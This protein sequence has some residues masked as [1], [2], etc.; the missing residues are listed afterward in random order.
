MHAIGLMSG[1]SL[2]GVDAA[3]IGTDGER[4]ENFGPTYYRP[5]S[6]PERALLRRALADAVPITERTARPGVLAEAESLVTRTHAEAVERLIVE[7]NIARKGI[8]VVGFHG[9]T[10]L[11]RPQQKLTIQ[12]GDGPALAKRLGIL[13]VQDFRAADVAAGGQGAPLVPVFHRAI[14]STIERPHPVAVLNIGGVA[15]VTFVDGGPD[16]IACDTGP[17]NALIDDFMRA[18]TGASYDDNGDAAA[19]G[20]PDE[21]FIARVLKDPFFDKRPPKSLDRNAFAFANIGLPEFSVADG[22]ATLSALTVAA[23]ARIVPRLPEP[24]RAWIVAGG[25]ARNRT[26][27][28]ML[29]ARLAPATVETADDVGWSADALEAQAFAFLAVRCL[30]DLPITFPTTSGAPKPMRGGVVAMP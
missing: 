11:H 17:G 16:P 4:I 18:R 21:A 5:Y 9:Q 15:N 8:D 6:E 20:N 27:M 14:V 26:L 30:R 28:R 24:P 13:V 19:G 29:A 2:D 7:N 1:T 3:L 10:V 12:I 22:A 25:G 23:V